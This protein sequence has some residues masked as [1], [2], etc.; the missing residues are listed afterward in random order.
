MALTNAGE[1]LLPYAECISRLDPWHGRKA[2]LAAHLA[3]AAEEFKD[4]VSPQ[5]FDIANLIVGEGVGL[6]QGILPAGEVVRR[7]ARDAARLS[8]WVPQTTAVSD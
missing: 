6:V 5:D 2:E 3:E 8:R 4:A 7:M 1:R